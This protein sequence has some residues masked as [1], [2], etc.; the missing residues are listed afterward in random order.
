[1]GITLNSLNPVDVLSTNY[2]EGNLQ[3]AHKA[4]VAAPMIKCL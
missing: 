4:N 3:F 1:M 2:A